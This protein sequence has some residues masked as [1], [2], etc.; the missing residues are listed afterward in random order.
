M[1]QQRWLATFQSLY[2][3]VAE[4]F[5]TRLHMTTALVVTMASNNTLSKTTQYS[6]MFQPILVSRLVFV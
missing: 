3:K 2:G 1:A 6:H 4:D 5:Q